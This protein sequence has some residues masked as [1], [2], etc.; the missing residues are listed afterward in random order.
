MLRVATL[1]ASLPALLAQAPAELRGAWVARDSLQNKESLREAIEKLA[2]ANFNAVLV[3]VWSRGYPL[4]P[5]KV[6]ERETGI[7]I[8]PAFAGRDVIAECLEAASPLGVACIPWAEYGFVAGYSGY[9]PGES[10]KG[11]I[12]DRHPDW[13][14]KTRAGEDAFPV[15]GT[16]ESFYWLAHAHPDAQAWLIELMVE[17]AKNYK[18]D[19]IEFDRARYPQLDC[20]Y[21][22][23]TREIYA[24]EHDGRSPPENERDRAWMN[25]RA[26]KLNEFSSRLAKAVKAVDWR[27]TITNAPITYP[28]G[29]EMF[30][31]DYP[32]WLK[33]GSV[34][35]VSPQIYR[36]D[37]P[38]FTRELDNNIR[39]LP[40]TSRLVPGVDITNS[41][42][43][44]VLI[45]M[46][47]E[48]RTRNL[49][50]NIIWYYQSLIS[51]GSLERLKATVYLEKASLPWRTSQFQPIP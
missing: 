23:K 3:N 14:A 16:R 28:Y 7:L 40:D 18:V 48:A 15:S 1:L 46:I 26:R 19:S 49:P 41:R 13:L 12:F 29:F 34:D 20:G 35:F 43:P 25:W 37:V 8:D 45:R 42:D 24:A 22:D 31:Q 47:E 32:A 2:E 6:F 39:F 5:S 30:L 36:A 33:D 17:I 10:K 4:W 51:T 9:F 21:D 50:G 44:N 38:S 27:I 11:P